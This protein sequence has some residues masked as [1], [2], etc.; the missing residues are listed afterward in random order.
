ME[1]LV[2]LKPSKDEEPRNRNQPPR[3]REQ[4]TSPLPPFFVTTTLVEGEVLLQFVFT[5]NSRQG[6][7]TILVVIINRPAE[8]KHAVSA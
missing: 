6:E 7:Y 3:F 4:F 5:A 1:F 2:A 8:W